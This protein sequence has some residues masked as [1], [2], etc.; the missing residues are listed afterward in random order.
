MA[1][2]QLQHVEK[3]FG[4]LAAV[5]GVSME[6]RQGEILAIVGPNGAGKSTLLKLV[7]GLHKASSGTVTFDGQNI[8]NLPAHRIRQMGIAMAQQTPQHFSSMTVMDNVVVGAMFG[9]PTGYKND[10]KAFELAGVA[11]EAVGLADRRHD[12]VSNLT[13]QQQ[14]F[15]QIARSIAGQPRILAL[16]EVM[17][18][19]T[20]GELEASIEI[21]RNIRDQ[22]NLTI[23]WVEHVMKAVRSLAE[24]TVVLNFG[25]VLTQGLPNEVLNHPDVIE[26]Y[27]GKE[28]HHA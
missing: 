17:A 10:K 6:A 26:A 13:L 16:D 12:L 19:L 23:I 15:L 22:F 21:V 4:G 5:G 8:T 1:L 25:T 20:D 11:L 24:R 18:G 28:S 9:T 7:I 14:R 27:L 2:L 3:H